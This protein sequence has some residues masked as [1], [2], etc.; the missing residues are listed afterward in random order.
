MSANSQYRTSELCTGFVIER[1]L[2]YH[3]RQPGGAIWEIPDNISC[4]CKVS[5]PRRGAVMTKIIATALLLVCISF[6]P[7]AAK[8]LD[9]DGLT[10]LVADKA[11]LS[12]EDA[13]KAV[14]AVFDTITAS[15]SRGEK[16][17]LVDFGTFYVVNRAA[18]QG[19]NPRTGE[20]IQIGASKQP[21]FKAAKA[22]KAAVKKAVNE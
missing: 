7:T 10:A 5:E 13:A 18:R 19:R 4:A 17:S 9:K 16:V 22:L 2:C 12:P 14:D 1:P 8:T 20:R 3:H 21:K 6:Q 15:L 11:N